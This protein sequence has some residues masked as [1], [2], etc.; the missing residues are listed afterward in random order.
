M[1]PLHDGTLA[2]PSAAPV[3]AMAGPGGGAI[4]NSCTVV[5]DFKILVSACLEVTYFS[6]RTNGCVDCDTIPPRLWQQ[7]S[8]GTTNGEEAV[9]ATDCSSL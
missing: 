8:N 9:A 6:S 3:I 4:T 5:D 1:R 7:P 2:R